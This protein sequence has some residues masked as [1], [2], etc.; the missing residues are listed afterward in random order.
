[1]RPTSYRLLHPAIYLL[2]GNVWKEFHEF[3]I[4]PARLE[5][6]SQVGS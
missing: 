4:I 6:D 5:A 1:M 2:N 3:Q